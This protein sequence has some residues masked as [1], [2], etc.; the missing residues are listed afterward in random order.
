LIQP[1]RIIFDEGKKEALFDDGV[2]APGNRKKPGVQN[3]TVWKYSEA[4]GGAGQSPIAFDIVAGV[5]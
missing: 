4:L 2:N 1:L 5:V 3:P